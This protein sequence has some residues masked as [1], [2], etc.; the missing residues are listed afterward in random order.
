MDYFNPVGKPIFK[1]SVRVTNG[2]KVNCGPDLLIH[3]FVC[4]CNLYFGL[5][6][7]VQA[8]P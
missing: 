4:L 5:L 7:V 8:L 1:K 3:L 6:T 2:Y